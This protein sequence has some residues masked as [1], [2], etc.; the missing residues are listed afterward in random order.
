MRKS[1]CLRSEVGLTIDDHVSRD[2]ARLDGWVNPQLFAQCVS[3]ELE[4]LILHDLLEE[5]TCDLACI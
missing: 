4:D 1:L 3:L 5:I 2:L